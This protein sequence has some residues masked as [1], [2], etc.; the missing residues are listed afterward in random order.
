MLPSDTISR[1][2]LMPRAVSPPESGPRTRYSVRGPRKT[3]MSRWRLQAD[4]PSDALLDFDTPILAMIWIS[5][6]AKPVQVIIYPREDLRVRLSDHKVAL[7]AVAFE[8]GTDGV[9]KKPF[10]LIY[11]LVDD[12]LDIDGRPFLA[13]ETG[14]IPASAA[15]LDLDH[16]AIGSVMRNPYFSGDQ[17]EIPSDYRTWAPQSA[18]PILPA[19]LSETTEYLPGQRYSLVDDQALWRWAPP[20][21]ELFDK[22]P[23]IKMLD[24]RICRGVP[25]MHHQNHQDPFYFTSVDVRGIGE[26]IEEQWSHHAAN[27]CRAVVKPVAP[28]L[29][30]I[31]DPYHPDYC[32]PTHEL[33]QLREEERVQR[34]ALVCKLGKAH[35]RA[36]K[37]NAKKITH[38]HLR[39]LTDWDTQGPYE[40]E[41]ARYQ[42]AFGKFVPDAE[43]AAW[44]ARKGPRIAELAA[45]RA[46]AAQIN[47]HD[48]PAMVVYLAAEK[49]FELDF[50]HQ[51]SSSDGLDEHFQQMAFHARTAE[52]LATRFN[53]D[54]QEIA[55]TASE[56]LV[57]YIYNPY[58]AGDARRTRFALEIRRYARELDP[59][60][61][62]GAAEG[63]TIGFSIT[64]CFAKSPEKSLYSLQRRLQQYYKCVYTKHL[65]V[66]VAED[67]RDDYEDMVYE[68]R[69][70]P[71]S[72]YVPP[73]MLWDTYD[74]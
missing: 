64:N 33:Q 51:F 11:F 15:K 54:T 41:L 46:A 59:P 57:F 48:H 42:E 72:P 43:N 24:G 63:T 69:E 38:P 62:P 31:T 16:I 70:N 32:T 12:L 10:A 3:Q 4:H 23:F 35:K 37:A 25:V 20:E 58:P 73:T 29:P 8:K 67:H 55:A 6:T 60:A 21:R 13:P 1:T 19:T 26:T 30:R 50:G 27:E 66:T 7:G 18:P 36:K 44:F 34:N 9:Q 14:F 65:L 40:L 47:H 5:D 61:E 49:A 68:N 71:H 74:D 22:L 56:P 52:A 17:S 28:L 53:D 45:A 39:D 2:I